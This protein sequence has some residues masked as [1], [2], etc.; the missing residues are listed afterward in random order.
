[1]LVLS[2]VMSRY[3]AKLDRMIS[4]MA[5]EIVF[6]AQARLLKSLKDPKTT[7][8]L[9]TSLR[10]EEDPEGG[11]RVFTDKPYARFVEFGTFNQAARPFLTPAAEEV[12]VTYTRLTSDPK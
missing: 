4:G 5:E 9:V 6:G 11:M 3:E 2:T 10:M 12:K 7:S 8:P 1:M